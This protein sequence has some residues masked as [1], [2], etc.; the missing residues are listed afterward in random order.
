MIAWSKALTL[1]DRDAGKRDVSFSVDARYIRE[2][3]EG[4]A[5]RVFWERAHAMGSRQQRKQIR[6]ERQGKRALT[7]AQRRDKD[8]L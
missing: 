8:E 6:E 7:Q 5:A 3:E 1:P 2:T 4:R